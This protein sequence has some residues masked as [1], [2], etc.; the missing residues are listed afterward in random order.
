MLS[1]FIFVF[2]LAFIFKFAYGSYLNFI[3]IK[4]LKTEFELEK[5][6]KSNKQININ[7]KKNVYFVIS[8]A[9][10]DFDL[11]ERKY[12]KFYK[13]ENII[14]NYR[15]SFLNEGLKIIDNS[16]NNTS[17]KSTKQALGAVINLDDNVPIDGSKYKYQYPV[18]MKFFSYTNLYK[19]LNENDYNFFWIGNIWNNC[20]LYNSNLCMYEENNYNKNFYSLRNLEYY[21]ESSLL[22]NLIFKK[23]NEKFHYKKINKKN[24]TLF[25]F[26]N[27]NYYKNKETIKNENNFLFFHDYG[28]HPPFVYDQNCNYISYPYN[29]KKGYAESYVCNLKELLSFVK[30]I[31]END[32]E[33]IIVITGDHGYFEDRSN[34]LR[35]IKIQ[36]CEYNQNKISQSFS[37]LVNTAISCENYQ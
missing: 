19:K 34:I 3:E 6:I 27:F 26:I 9:V 31:N 2:S 35:M 37:Y 18:A 28:A 1:N 17:E 20:H 5:N 14:N 22:G 11:F 32:P 23:F 25:D 24:S 4:N 16:K 36:N 12:A 29:S 21:L 13:D 30:F 15:K 10:V 8:D 7:N 33:S